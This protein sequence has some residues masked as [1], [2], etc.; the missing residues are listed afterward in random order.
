MS[1]SSRQAGPTI[2]IIYLHWQESARLDR[3]RPAEKAPVGV[4][5][6]GAK[7]KKTGKAAK[8][9]SSLINKWQAVRKVSS[10]FICVALAGQ[11]KLLAP[12]TCSGQRRPQ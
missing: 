11:L 9:A 5:L 6:L 12:M 2:L 1:F 3:K 4:G 7:K 8:N 10:P